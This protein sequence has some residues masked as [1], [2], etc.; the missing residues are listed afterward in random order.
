[1]SSSIKNFSCMVHKTCVKTTEWGGL[2]VL[3]RHVSTSHCNHSKLKH[4]HIYLSPKSVLV[5]TTNGIVL[6]NDMHLPPPPFSRLR[7]FCT[8]AFFMSFWLRIFC[9]V[10]T[11]YILFKYV[12][13]SFWNWCFYDPIDLPPK[14]IPLC[15]KPIGKV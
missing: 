9:G 4:S 8:L 15:A 3:M 2:F 14:E 7:S 10:E 1:M 13:P 5:T 6:V 11:E 12:C